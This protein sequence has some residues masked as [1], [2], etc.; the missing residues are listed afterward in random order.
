MKKS[1]FICIVLTFFSLN[2]LKAQTGIKFGLRTGFN[3]ATQYGTKITD[4]SYDVETKPRYGFSGA[5]FLRFPITDVF[6]IQQEFMYSQ[7]GSVQNVV[8]NEP[9][10]SNTSSRYKINYFEVPIIF[11]YNF[12]NMGNVRLYG[13]S[14]F[15]LSFLLNGKYS[16]DGSVEFMGENYNIEESG[17][18]DGLDG[19]D[20]N[21]IYGLG[22]EFNKEY[23]FDYRQ[24]I[25]WNTLLMP[26][27]EG[28]DPAPLRN[29]TY[30]ISIGMFL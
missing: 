14:G 12:L 16:M 26:T 8:S 3:I 23:F 25:G 20:Y 2:A 30:S 28:G 6:S 22:I 10:L 13:C 1:I 9:P 7:K 4:N 11:S 18:T 29:Q 19:F 17:D 27:V 15:G 5:F 21:F 24:T